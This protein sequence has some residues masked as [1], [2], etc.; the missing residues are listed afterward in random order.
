MN[1]LETLKKIIAEEMDVEVEI[2]ADTK[3]RDDLEAD[4]LALMEMVMAVEE[5][6]EVK[7]EEEQLGNLETVGDLVKLI[8]E[9]Q[10]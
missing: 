10:A 4:S 1:T 7:I 5:E 9:Q 6:F 2:T 3:L 8:E